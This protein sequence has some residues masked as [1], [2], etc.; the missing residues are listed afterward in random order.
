LVLACNVTVVLR[1]IKEPTLITVCFFHETQWVIDFFSLEKPG[2][3]VYLQQP[4]LEVMNLAVLG[5]S[6]NLVAG[7]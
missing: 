7:C 5:F 2:T 6:E 1:R 3:R 4:K